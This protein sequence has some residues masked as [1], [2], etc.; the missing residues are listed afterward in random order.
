MAG[1]TEPLF[2]VDLGIVIVQQN[3]DDKGDPVCPPHCFFF[4]ISYNIGGR[5]ALKHGF[6]ATH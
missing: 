2:R 6:V 4:Y 3:S 1:V 5:G